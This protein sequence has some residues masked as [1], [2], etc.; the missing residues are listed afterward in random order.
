MENEIENKS[1]S[2]AFGLMELR[3][4]AFKTGKV[5]VYN[6]LIKNLNMY[7]ALSVGD[8]S[9]IADE[10]RSGNVSD[11]DADVL[12]L[13]ADHLEGKIR[14]SRGPSRKVSRKDRDLNVF[15]EF[16]K[17]EVIHGYD[18]AITILEENLPLNIGRKSIEK[19][20]TEHNKIFEILEKAHDLSEIS[21]PK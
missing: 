8:T 18:S 2:C 10:L 17:M 12:G 13:L 6:K 21:H 3:K 15:L 16:K 19:I 11:I 9:P 4:A 14:K 7:L 5:D 1:L 20:I